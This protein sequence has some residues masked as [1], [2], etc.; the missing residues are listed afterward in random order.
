M[1]TCQHEWV[2]QCQARY[3]CDPP[4]GYSYQDAHYP[5]SK[6]LGGTDTIKLWYPDHII[7]GCLQTLEFQYPCIDTRVRDI[8]SRIVEEVYPEYVELYWQVYKLCQSW[9][10]QKG[11]KKTN[12]VKDELG[13][14]VHAVANACKMNSEKDPSGKSINASKGAQILNDLLHQEKTEEGK[15]RHAVKMG[16]SAH[17]ELN[18]AGKSVLGVKASEKLNAEKTDE[19]KSKNAVKGGKAGGRRGASLTNS[20]RWICLVTGHVT[21]SGPLTKYQRSRGIDTKLRKRLG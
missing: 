9:A 8:E 1:I 5:L 17:T 2:E 20:Q 12:E 15:S 18:E 11:S 7:Q 3:R 16:R 14:S 6:G 4:A 10:G 19:G 21:T 13:R